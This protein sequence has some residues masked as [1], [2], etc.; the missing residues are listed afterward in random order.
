MRN[1]EKMMTENEMRKENSSDSI[2]KEDTPVDTAKGSKD[3]EAV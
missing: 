3:K 1:D 2:I